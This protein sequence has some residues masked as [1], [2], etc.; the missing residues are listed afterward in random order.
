TSS[1]T[2]DV[3]NV[4][5]INSPVHGDDRTQVFSFDQFTGHLDLGQYL[6]TERLTAETRLH[7][8]EVDLVNVMDEVLNVIKTGSRCKSHGNAQSSGLHLFDGAQ[9]VS[10]AFKLDGYH[11]GT[12][13][14]ETVD[15]LFGP[16]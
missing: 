10:T 16:V 1:V 2:K 3:G 14:D 8:H 7:C 11:V 15:D 12:C 5:G 4:L 13:T 9:R 6:S